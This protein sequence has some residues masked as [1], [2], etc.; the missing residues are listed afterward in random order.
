VSE[1][2]RRDRGRLARERQRP[3]VVVDAS[4]A[5]LWFTPEP[6]SQL[7]AQLEH[8]DS[9]LLAPDILPVEVANAL[10]K[11]AGRQEMTARQV[12]DA[13]A[14]LASGTVVMIPSR[15]LLVRA[16]RLA[17]EFRRPVYDCLYLALASEWSARIATADI[18]LQKVAARFRLPLWK[19]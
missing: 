13:L 11:K 14:N 9:M 16:T 8:S 5:V 12:E 15:T 2:R 3:P 6:G 7:A 1:G 4:I 18:D 17:L 19:R 10:C